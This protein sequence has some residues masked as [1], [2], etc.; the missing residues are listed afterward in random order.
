VSPKTETPGPGAPRTCTEASINPEV[1][2]SVGAAVSGQAS[3]PGLGME[4]GTDLE[5]DAV[6][7][8]AVSEQTGTDTNP[9]A[10]IS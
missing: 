3:A 7:G 4:V 5:V 10:I 2:V 1:D 9:D 8:A 6:I